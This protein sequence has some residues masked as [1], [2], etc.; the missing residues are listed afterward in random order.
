MSRRWPGKAAEGWLDG[1]DYLSMRSGYLACF[2]PL[3]AI[4][5]NDRAMSSYSVDGTP[6]LPGSGIPGQPS[7][8]PRVANLNLILL[9]FIT[10][11]GS[12]PS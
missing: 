9:R 5:S 2:F 6:N 8:R 3:F 4:A 7:T 11:H 10:C 1:I 12:L